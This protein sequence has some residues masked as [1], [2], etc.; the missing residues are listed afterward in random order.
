MKLEP[1]ETQFA[2]LAGQQ[3][4]NSSDLRF[5]VM[6]GE[7]DEPARVAPNVVRYLFVRF[8]I[9]GVAD[10]KDDGLIDPY[11]FGLAQ[12]PTRVVVRGPRG[13]CRVVLA[14]VFPLACMAM[15]V[16]HTS[17]AFRI[18]RLIGAR[19][20]CHSVGATKQQAALDK[21]TPVQGLLLVWITRVAA[22]RSAAWEHGSRIS[23]IGP[24]WRLPQ[25]KGATFTTHQECQNPSR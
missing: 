9:G 21:I 12:D 20:L 4:P 19:I 7:A 13:T 22:S 3:G 24:R 17:S 6:L 25:A 18:W 2:N 8:L 5:R 10:W 1:F 11:L 14:V 23:R 15:H 16:D